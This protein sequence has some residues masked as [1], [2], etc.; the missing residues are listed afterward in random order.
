[1][2]KVISYAQFLF[3]MTC[4]IALFLHTVTFTD[5]A[6]AL[7]QYLLLFNTVSVCVVLWG[8]ELINENLSEE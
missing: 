8:D 2:I 1:M 6:I 5:E 3:I 4:S 7:F